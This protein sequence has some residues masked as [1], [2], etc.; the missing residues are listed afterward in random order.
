MY[1][2]FLRAL[3]LS[4]YDTEIELTIPALKDCAYLL[5]LM[6]LSGI[7][8]GSLLDRQCPRVCH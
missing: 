4:E 6:Q 5:M 7:A 8:S 3:A 2:N 1:A